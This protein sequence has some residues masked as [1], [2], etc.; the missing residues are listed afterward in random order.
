MNVAS[1]CSLVQETMPGDALSSANI[2]SVLSTFDRNEIEAAKLAEQKAVSEDVR[3]FASRMVTEH[4]AL[5]ENTRHLGQ[6]IGIR[7]QK[8]AL[9]T[10]LEKAHQELMEQLQGKS[11]RDFDQAYIE[12][13]V[14][15]HIELYQA[16]VELTDDPQL[17]LYL[18]QVRP[19]VLDHLMAARAAERQ[20]V[21]QR[22]S[23]YE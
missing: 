18:R 22:M 6:Q 21:T 12:Q 15:Q 2:L 10:S 20:V 19:D 5:A 7:P 23:Q 14:K 17:Q 4:N 1:G 16:T 13:E 9:A 8:P 11:G 3:S